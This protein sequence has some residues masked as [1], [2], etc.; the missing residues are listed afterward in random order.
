[1]ALDK[2]VDS[3][4]L[5]SDLTSVANAIRTKGGT[6]AQLAFPS[7][8]VSAIGDIS[9]GG[10]ATNDGI[11]TGTEPSG[12]ITITASSMITYAFR[13]NTAITNIYAP[14]LTTLP[15]SYQTE[16]MTSLDKFIAPNLTS[17][18]YSSFRSGGL[19][20]GIFPKSNMGASNAFRDCSRLE[21]LDVLNIDT[22]NTL[23]EN[24]P[25]L[26]TVIIRKTSVTSVGG[27][28]LYAST[29]NN[30]MTIYVP[31]ALIDEYKQ[32]TNWSTAYANG[33]I[34]FSALENSIYASTTWWQS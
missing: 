9:T 18:T 19:K 28:V 1:M 15:G 23:C 11:A 27:T 25:N 7:G 20:Q 13:G 29:K 17:L 3:S 33:Y 16:A 2:L 34:T 21:L 30:V 12:D 8:F 32:A 22:T 14:N 31:S 26:K 10:G 5:D 6:S 24:S 4:Q